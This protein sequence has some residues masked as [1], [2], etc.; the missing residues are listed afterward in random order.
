[1]LYEDVT[2]QGGREPAG[3]GAP[4]NAGDEVSL[5]ER[6]LDPLRTSLTIVQ[7]TEYLARTGVDSPPTVARTIL[8]GDRPNKRDDHVSSSKL[9]RHGR[10]LRVADLQTA[11]LWILGRDEHRSG[12]AL[13]VRS[14]RESHEAPWI[15][16]VEHLC[17]EN[18][19]IDAHPRSLRSRGSRRRESRETGADD[20]DAEIQI[21]PSG[22]KLAL[23]DERAGRLRK[24]S[25][26]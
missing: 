6:R 13:G 25:V 16:D 10:A 20:V 11:Q 3:G 21:I 19:R 18:R 8:T 7:D 22:V 4:Y 23:Q 2:G 24:S 15:R 9:V 1:L 26:R 14:F 17:L 5:D 12:Y